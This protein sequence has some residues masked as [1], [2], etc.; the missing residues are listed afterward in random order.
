MHAVYTNH[1]EASW[2]SFLSR[3]PAMRPTVAQ[4]LGDLPAGR[5]IF[6]VKGHVFAVV[7]GVCLDVF[8]E[9]APRRRVEGYW[10][11]KVAGSPKATFIALA[12]SS[13]QLELAW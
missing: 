8:S 1:E 3:R 11:M 13:Q 4:L 2:V 12:P 5:Y 6:K 9:P 10:A 7:D